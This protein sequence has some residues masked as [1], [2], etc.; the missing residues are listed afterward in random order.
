[1]FFSKDFKT[2]ILKNRVEQTRQDHTRTKYHENIKLCIES[3]QND[4]HNINIIADILNSIANNRDDLY[5]INGLH[6]QR[7]QTGY[8][9]TR[10]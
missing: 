8:K 1:M 3:L 4:S 2:K 6:I 9:I 7:D 10:N 5:T